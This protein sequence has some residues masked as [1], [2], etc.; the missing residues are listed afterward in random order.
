MN[1]PHHSHFHMVNVM[2]HDY[3]FWTDMQWASLVWIWRNCMRSG[4]LKTLKLSMSWQV[5]IKQFSHGKIFV[6]SRLIIFN[7]L[8]LASLLPHKDVV[9]LLYD[10]SLSLLGYLWC[11][12]FPMKPQSSTRSI[13]KPRPN[14]PKTV[15]QIDCY[16]QRS[17]P[18]VH[19]CKIYLLT[20][21]DGVGKEGQSAYP[22]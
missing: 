11:H 20:K 8:V 17:T 9:C 21:V 7:T 18:F 16:L 14:S 15:N 19:S 10:Y 12:F 3:L 6:P 2:F 4:D 1:S 22:M 5:G 13:I